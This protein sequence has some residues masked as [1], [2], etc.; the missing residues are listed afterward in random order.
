M[1]RLIV[2]YLNPWGFRRQQEAERVLA[3]RQR[4]GDG[5]RRCRRPIR[6]DLPAGHDLGFRMERIVPSNAGGAEAL[7]NLCLT[8]WRCNAKSRDDTGEVME[9]LRP[10]R[11]AELFSKSRKRKKA[12]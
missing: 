4:D 9:R 7:D 1:R 10:K 12:A 3:L 8:H 6:F 5:C 11:E 2:K